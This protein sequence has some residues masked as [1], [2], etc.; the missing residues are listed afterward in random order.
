MLISVAKIQKKM[1][2]PPYNDN[3]YFICP[4]F[5]RAIVR[6]SQKQVSYL[7]HVSLFHETTGTHGT[8]GTHKK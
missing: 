4:V 5:A 2:I 8:D 3:F 6:I 7:S 1:I